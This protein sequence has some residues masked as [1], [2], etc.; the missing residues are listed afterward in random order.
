MPEALDRRG[1]TR[2]R[3]NGAMAADRRWMPSEMRLAGRIASGVADRFV[4]KPAEATASLVMMATVVAI[5]A[6]ALFLQAGRHP[7]PLLPTRVE[8]A[9]AEPAF[10]P[11]PRPAMTRD[12]AVPRP[13]PETVPA[14]NAGDLT[15]IDRE[16]VRDIQQALSERG[17]YAGD[18]DGLYGPQ[19]MRA[20][21]DFQSRSGLAATG[22]PSSDLLARIRL[23]AGL[24]MQL[25][26]TGSTERPAAAPAADRQ[27]SAS[28]VTAVQM[29]LTDLGYGA[30]KADGIAG[31]ETRNAIRRFELDRGMEIS[32]RID[33]RLLAEL[34]RV[35][36]RTLF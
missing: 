10:A 12:G 35:L 31:N 24:P 21:R 9:A 7:A 32:G 15:P 19:T 29:V 18:I 2:M 36:G 6:N 5:A 1:S 13:A 28:V 4:D 33:N 16:L 20:I 23:G 8:T 30:I 25:M 26:S 11:V 27:P 22:A 3:G 34:E 14:E 17:L